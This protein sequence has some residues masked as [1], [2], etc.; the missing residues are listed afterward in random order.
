MSDEPWQFFGNTDVMAR[1]KNYIHI[2]WWIIVTPPFTN[3]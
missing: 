2:N 1:M 3:V